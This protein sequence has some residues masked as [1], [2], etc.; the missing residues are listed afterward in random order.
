[1]TQ[2]FFKMCRL[3]NN[4][5]TLSTISIL[6]SPIFQ[7][8]GGHGSRQKKYLIAAEQHLMKHCV[9]VTTAVQKLGCC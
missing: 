3:M 4:L 7:I 8:R 1:M 2:I 9:S 6:I 5:Q